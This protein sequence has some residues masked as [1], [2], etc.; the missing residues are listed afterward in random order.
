MCNVT[1]KMQKNKRNYRDF[2]RI[3][4]QVYDFT[5]IK[6]KTKDVH[7]NYTKERAKVK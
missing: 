3:L 1:I 4:F 5:K 6:Y 7:I 2:L